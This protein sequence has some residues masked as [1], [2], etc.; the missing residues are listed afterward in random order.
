M[1][2][3][4]P[5]GQSA[6][7]RRT[8]NA[9][10]EIKKTLDAIEVKVSF[11]HTWFSDGKAISYW[12]FFNRFNLETE[13]KDQAVNVKKFFMKYL[14]PMIPQTKD[15]L[16]NLQRLLMLTDEFSDCIN[17]SCSKCWLFSCND[18]LFG[19]IDQAKLILKMTF[20]GT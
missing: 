20:E 17:R 2:K 5:R 6:L 16:A 15:N 7:F 10:T 14:P 9:L 18:V 19:R 11:K 3:E 13:K 8:T 4:N 12:A 1:I